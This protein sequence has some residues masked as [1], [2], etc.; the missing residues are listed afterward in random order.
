MKKTYST[1]LLLFALPFGLE[2]S[3]QQSIWTIHASTCEA[4]NPAQSQWMEWRETGLVNRDPSRSLWVMCPVMSKFFDSPFQNS[5]IAML[6]LND[7]TQSIQ[8]NCILRAIDGNSES[9]VSYSQT[10]TVFPGDATDFAWELEN[11]SILLPSIACNLP[12]NGVVAG[13]LAGYED[14]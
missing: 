1:T 6:V 3:A 8:V 4:I 7:N 2:A 11:Q 14:F 13:I 10:K 12:P 9:L 5:Y